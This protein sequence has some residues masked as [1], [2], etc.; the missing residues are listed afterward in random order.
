MRNAECGMAG[1]G[2]V[3]CT[4]YPFNSSFPITHSAFISFPI[5]HSAFI[6]FPRPAAIPPIHH[7]RRAPLG[8]AVIAPLLVGV[9]GDDRRDRGG[10]A[11]GV[12]RHIRHVA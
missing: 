7:P 1:G 2:S 12:E 11:L 8:R 9:L 3:R 4:T 5:P 10:A 6:S